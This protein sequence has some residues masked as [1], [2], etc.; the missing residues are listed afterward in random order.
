ME[1]RDA[2]KGEVYWGQGPRGHPARKGS[3]HLELDQRPA[4]RRDMQPGSEE[5]EVTVE[6]IARGAVTELSLTHTG[7]H[8]EKLRKEHDRGWNDCLH[9]LQEVLRQN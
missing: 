6:F 4:G 8:N 2:A 3:V 1:V 9:I 5:T 7:F